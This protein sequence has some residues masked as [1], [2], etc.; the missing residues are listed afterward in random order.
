MT[1]TVMYR[2]LV[3]TNLTSIFQDSLYRIVGC[4]EVLKF[5]RFVKSKC[6]N[7]YTI[8]IA[9]Y[10]A[11]AECKYLKKTNYTVYHISN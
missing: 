10:W 3:L 2:Y 1:T 8:R 9:E 6:S 7:I 5:R 4:F 11:F